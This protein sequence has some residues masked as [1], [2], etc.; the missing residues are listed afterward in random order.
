MITNSFVVVDLTKILIKNS[1]FLIYFFK[2]CV[3]FVFIIIK[4]C[5]TKKKQT[6][7][8]FPYILC[9]KKFKKKKK[10]YFKIY[11]H[12]STK[13]NLNNGIINIVLD[14]VFLTI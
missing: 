6:I 10:N 3:Y 11:F 12:V 14:C 5:L 9:K 4:L 1:S 13:K 2:F 7:F 8:S